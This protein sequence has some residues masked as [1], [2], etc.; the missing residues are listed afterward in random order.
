[1][2]DQ[3]PSRTPGTHVTIM[4]YHVDEHGNRSPQAEQTIHDPIGT[5]DGIKRA[6]DGIRMAKVSAYT[7]HMLREDDPVNG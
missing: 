6:Y 7:V 4:I 1:M 2:N 3:E 5:V